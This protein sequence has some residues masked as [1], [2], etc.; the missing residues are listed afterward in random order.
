MRK[1]F[2][3]STML[4]IAALMPG[5]GAFAQYP[6]LT[7]EEIIDRHIN[8]VGG[9]E[10]LAKL[11]TR[12]AIGTVKKDDEVEAKMAIVSE[13]P[14]RVSAKYIFTKFDHQMTFD[15]ANP[16]FR[17]NFALSMADVRDK[18]A[19]IL[20]SGFMFNDI[21]LY[22][23]LVAPQSEGVTLEAKGT[24]KIRGN[25]AY[26]VNIKRSKKSP[27]TV[28][29]DAENFMWIRSEFGQATIQKMMGK[30]TNESVSRAE[31]STNVD[32][33]CDT[34]D[35]RDVDGIKLPFQFVHT[36]TWPILN[37]KLVGEIKGTIAEYRHN[38]PIDPVM[39]Q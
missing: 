20:A 2:L 16:L 18:F 25:T 7:A 5:R 12:I 35:F 30:F 23:A 10:A 14:N 34:Y 32:F 38:V 21:S 39:F 31:D 29:I 11:K 15:G 19:T 27:V 22:N 28:F 17:P 6:K 33:Y 26:A 24:K 4:L 1:I 36:I 9:K 3:P 13:A 37:S 8:A